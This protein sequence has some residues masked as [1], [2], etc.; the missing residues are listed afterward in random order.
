MIVPEEQEEVERLAAWLRARQGGCP[1]AAA[2][3]R[4]TPP[5]LLPI[6]SLRRALC[7]HTAALQ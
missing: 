5:L 3:A 4:A 7:W 1:P 6:S 2:T